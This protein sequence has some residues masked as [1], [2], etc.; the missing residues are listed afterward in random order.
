M[1]A[2]NHVTDRDRR[3]AASGW[4][5]LG[6]LCVGYFLVL[7]D[8][9]VV[10]V[11]LP[12]IGLGLHASVSGLQW[13]V[14]AY[15]VALAGLLLAGSTIGDLRGHK[16][17]VLAG[18]AVF[19]AASVVC[20][21]APSVVLLVVARACQGV[22]AALLLPGTLAIISGLFEDAGERAKAIGI[23]AGVG[24][25]ALPAGPLFG[26]LLVQTLGWRWVFLMNVPI[27][28]IA[29]VVALR[30]VPAQGALRVGRIDWAGIGLA[31]VTLTSATVAVIDA[32]GRGLD[33]AS[34]GAAV[35]AGLAAVCL[36][37]WEAVCPDPML[38]VALLKRRA[39]TT[40][41]AVAGLMNFSTLGL[42]FVLT[43]YLQSIQHWSALA[44]GAGMLPLFVPLALFAPM[45][46]RLIARYG[47][48]LV[49]VF[50][51]A[52]CAAGVI[53]LAAWAASSP[54]RV[55]LPGMLS[56]GVGLS[57]LTPAVVAASVAAVPSDRAGLASGM[58]NTARQTGGAIGIAVFGAVAGSPQDVGP[59]MAALHDLGLVS[60]VLL[61]AAIGASWAFIPSKLAARPMR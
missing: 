5:V 14:D 30:V 44:A 17:V 4:S 41:N 6:V 19:V 20:G 58:N 31:V 36:C 32:G 26:G 37:R 55:L 21:L 54:Y 24:S 61:L 59:F 15:A 11:A 46:G 53:Q 22:G 49:M 13:V 48:R 50:G 52:L 1:N 47:A 7:L 35:V 45:G 29:G 27:G 57:L 3:T 23:W 33:G 2:T 18:L 16:P 56:W 39:F 10:N 25:L 12:S 34:L 51:L 38:P 28:V 40:A 60:G 42:L 43:L 9:T 8:V